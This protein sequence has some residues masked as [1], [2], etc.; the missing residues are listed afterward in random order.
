MAKRLILLGLDG[1]TFDLF[2]PWMEQGIL[3]NMARIAANG[4]WGDLE[5]TVPPTTPTAWSA[6]LTGKNPGRHGI[7]DFRHS[8]LDDPRRPLISSRSIKGRKL[9]HLINE[10]G[11]QAGFLNV[12]ITYPPEP[13][14][15]FM[16]SGL[17]T[18]DAGSD[19]TY[20][21][22]LKEHLNRAIGDYVVN[23]DIARYD[24]GREDDALA[25]LRDLT[26]AFEKR[27]QAMFWLMEA[28]DVD[29][30]MP[31]YI[32]PDR[33]Q[34]L[35]WKYLD[36]K[37]PDYHTARGQRMRGPL[38][39]AYQ[40]MDQMIGEL[41]DRLDGE[42]NLV[43]MSDH[44]FGSTQKWINVN[45]F[46]MDLGLLRLKPGAAI[47]KRLFYE[48]MRVEGSRLVR[49]L[50]PSSVRGAIRR[51]V[52]S[53]RSAF[54]SDIEW[55]IDWEHTRAFFV[56][57]ASQGIYINVRRVG[58]D[59]RRSPKP[60]LS[61]SA[62]LW[63]NSAEGRSGGDSRRQ[64]GGRDSHRIG[65]VEPGEEY[66]Q[67]RAFIKGKLLDLRDPRTG[68]KVMDA[69]YNREEVY[70]GAQTEYAPD[71]I[72]VARDYAYLGRN[73]FGSRHVIETSRY[74][75]NGFHRMNGIFM[76]YGPDIRPGLRV[77]GAAIVDIAPTV[78]HLMGLPIPD[79]MDGRPLTEIVESSIAAPTFVTAHTEEEAGENM[80]YTQQDAE[81]VAERLQA[82]GYLD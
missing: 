24:V 44:G 76:A 43:V 51:K 54:K 2:G 18:P 20:P 32:L 27:R 19:Y 72:F 34:H 62:S 71:L 33:I 41:L 29:F 40:A 36:P 82:L 47:R 70:A 63:I 14:N 4:A 48:A 64:S 11:K 74:M 26:Y 75:G 60:A 7:Y 9:W 56:S 66:N 15:G 58:G 53:G 38:V 23:I 28:T 55:S 35:F 45:K 8:P 50:L 6:C 49:T 69:V 67:L 25:F 52:R 17:M 1:A 73:L 12:P 31:V 65:I 10:A 30:F 61:P 80:E 42:T 68:E 13:V 3:P 22:D 46:L 79:D 16:V 78:L 21:V 5:S 59:S 77:E 37:Q 57:V 81:Y 39:E